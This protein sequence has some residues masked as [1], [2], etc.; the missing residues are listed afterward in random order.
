MISLG[1]DK[2]R[3]DAEVMLGV[4]KKKGYN[5]VNDEDNADVL[6]INTCGF[7]ESAKQE[8]V[9][10]ILEMA[11]YKETGRCR[12]LVAAGCLAQRYG[13]ELLREI[14]ELDAVIGT[15]SYTEIDSIVREIFDSQGRGLNRTGDM[16]Y[17]IDKS[18]D[19]ILTTPGYTAYLKIAEGCSN[20]CS[21]CI[22]PRIRGI[23]RSRSMETVLSEAEQLAHSGVKEIILVAQDTSKYGIDI[24]GKHMLHQLL[25]K[26]SR[27][28][29]VEWIRI[30]Y[31]YPEDI[32]EEL[33][34]VIK[35][36]EKVC[37]YLDIPIQH[38]NSEILRRMRR[39][40]SRRSI[41]ELIVKLRERIPGVVIRTSLIVGFP[42]ESEDQF[43]EL[44]EFL[45]EYKLDRAGVFIY[46]QEEDT[47]AALYEDQIDEKTKKE[48]RRRLLS[49]QNRISHNINS[50]KIGM[51]YKVLVEGRLDSGEF[52]GRT[53]GD[54]PDI[55]E[56]VYVICSDGELKPGDFINV[57]IT[58]ASEHD[59]SGES[60]KG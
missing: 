37:K 41:E 56:R 18:W 24:Y 59:I 47:D 20:E 19:R 15:G 50:N 45:K 26:I 6:V 51:I 43:M 46:S 39:A 2:N 13:D 58:G 54:A 32:Y 27:I 48:R 16:D 30:L 36:N 52:T 42:G 60:Y 34:S 9:D 4:L 3:V 8:S 22:I 55:D 57:K 10:A 38:I 29:G 28:D 1:C 21:Y 11:R 5:I 12:V 25:E 14:P 44:Y 7:I 31:C 49:L 17:D 33:I 40:S 35:N 23:Y 53:Y